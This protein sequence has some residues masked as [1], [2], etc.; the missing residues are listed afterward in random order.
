MFEVKECPDK[1]DTITVPA[2]TNDFEYTVSVDLEEVYD[3]NVINSDSLKYTITNGLDSSYEGSDKNKTFTYKFTKANGIKL[4]ISN[5]TNSDKRISVLVMPNNTIYT[6]NCLTHMTVGK[7]TRFNLRFTNLPEG[8]YAIKIRFYTDSTFTQIDNNGRFTWDSV[9]KDTNSN[10]YIKISGKN[11]VLSGTFKVPVKSYISFSLVKVT[12]ISDYD[13]VENND[14]YDYLYTVKETG[15][16]L[17]YKAYDVGTPAYSFTRSFKNF[18]KGTVLETKSLDKQ[19]LSYVSYKKLT[20]ISSNSGVKDTFEV[21]DNSYLFCPSDTDDYYFTSE[22]SLHFLVTD[23]SSGDS[24]END[25]TCGAHLEKGKQYAVT[26]SIIKGTLK[27]SSFSICKKVEVN[28]NSTSGSGFGEFVERLYNVAL[29]RPSEKEGKEFWCLHVGNGDLSGA[30]CA[31][32][33]L[34]SK[35]FN[36]RGLS[37]EEFVKVLYKTFF[38]RKAEEDPTGYN[39]WL[40]TLKTEGRDKAVEGFINS[41]EWCNLCATYGVKSGSNYVKASEASQNAIAFATRLYTECLGREPEQ[42]GLKYWSLGLTNH[43]LTGTQAAKEFFYSAEY[44]NK[45]LND[46]DYL[47]TLYKTFMGRDP[48]NEGK[49]YWM[50][51]LGSGMSRDEVFDSFSNSQ[52]FTQICKDYS[53]DR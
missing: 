23:I 35:E 22:T 3:V 15:A 41:E 33:F 4:K 10:G 36:D 31:K 24:V 43:E 45:A 37:D 20:D 11:D 27:T 17:V 6:K 42:E 34:L 53:I 19:G 9:D 50:D 5:N 29:N 28:T 2:N 32:E 26:I 30:A 8:E 21:I 51:K 49:A 39:F 13:T 48:E 16:Y 12:D 25:N 38:D 40:N 46:S 7:N 52:E 18:T 14:L 1:I 47:D 44:K